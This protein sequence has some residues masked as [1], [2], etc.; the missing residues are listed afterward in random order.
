M[1]LGKKEKRFKDWT[2]GNAG[3]RVGTRKGDR[4]RMTSEVER[5]QECGVLEAESEKKE[6][7]I[8]IS[9]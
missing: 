8:S 4:E 6:Y 3:R 9:I 5:N 7:Q 2:Q 1:N